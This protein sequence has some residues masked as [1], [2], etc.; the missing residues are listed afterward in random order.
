MNKIKDNALKKLKP[1]KQK[2]LSRTKNVSQ[3]GVRQRKI[4]SGGQKYTRFITN[5]PN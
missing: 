4:F 1:N 3:A 5:D 2:I